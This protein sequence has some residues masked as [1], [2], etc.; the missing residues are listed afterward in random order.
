MKKTVTTEAINYNNIVFTGKY[1]ILWKHTLFCEDTSNCSLILTQLSIISP[2]NLKKNVYW[3]RL[4][5]PSN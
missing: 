4:R 5:G 2:E 3:I 1:K